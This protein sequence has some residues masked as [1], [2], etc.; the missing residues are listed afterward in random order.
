MQQ[1]LQLQQQQLQQQV[2][3]SQANVMM[4]PPPPPL[5][6]NAPQMPRSP[7]Q[8]PMNIN[9]LSKQAVQLQQKIA[10]L[11]Q[12]L[13][14]MGFDQGGN[15]VQG[16]PM[17]GEEEQPGPEGVGG[18]NQGRMPPQTPPDAGLASQQMM[19]MQ[20]TP[21]PQHTPKLQTEKEVPLS[22]PPQ[23]P[24]NFTFEV[25]LQRLEGMRLGLSVL[26]VTMHDVAALWVN[27]VSEGGAVDAWNKSVC[28]A[29]QVRSGDAITRVFDAAG[30][31]AKMMEELQSH[32][33][34]RLAVLRQS[35]SGVQENQS[36]PAQPAA[37]AVPAPAVP[38]PAPA[39]AKAPAQFTPPPK[40]MPAQRQDDMSQAASR[41]LGMSGLAPGLPEGDQDALD[42]QLKAAG[43][44]GLPMPLNAHSEV[45]TDDAGEL[46][47][48][49][50]IEE[51]GANGPLRFTVVL[52]RK[53]PGR[54]GIDVVLKREANFCGLLVYTVS[55]GGR[56][57]AWNRQSQMPY[58]V[59]PGDHILEVND[60]SISGDSNAQ[61]DKFAVRMIQELSK[62]QKNVHFTVERAQN[63]LGEELA[64][65]QD[66][67]SLVLPGD[68][69][70]RVEEQTI[71]RQVG[72]QKPD[73]QD[74]GGGKSAQMK[75]AKASVA[76]PKASVAAP[77]WQPKGS[78]L[79]PGH[80]EGGD[81]GE[82]GEDDAK[83]DEEDDEEDEQTP[84]V[85]E[86]TKESKES[87]EE[88]EKDK[89]TE[90]APEATP[91]LVPKEAPPKAEP[92]P[93]PAPPQ[94]ALTP[95]ATAPAPAT[96][97]E[98]VPAVPAA[99]EP[100]VP[101]VKAKPVGAG[102]MSPPPKGGSRP[103]PPPPKTVAPVKPG[104]VS[105]AKA[106]A[107]PK[108]AEAKISVPAPPSGPAPPPPEL[109]K[110]PSQG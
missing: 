20:P 39:P 58:R 44:P 37:A 1:Q 73:A 41:P 56:V 14:L 89:A 85:S 45:P 94:P 47:G 99:K 34:I 71:P 103:L 6:P 65:P 102:E 72:A 15:Q 104:D 9:A 7:A 79:P 43:P 51:S 88:T 68:L 110:A 40:A 80:S 38:A 29:F 12:Q 53:G 69:R 106:K 62:D 81:E 26:P 108:E 35:G 19:R 42:A 2:I 55:E 31:H 54:L 67:E 86:D 48:S 32:R 25:Y 109:A 11:Q 84:S 98:P 33:N 100:K 27:D 70:R 105:K 107:E 93:E 78:P 82:D 57:D 59:L 30:D 77:R 50:D 76:L 22:T 64:L 23:D 95:P 96:P 87:K 61:N 83:E 46:F 4:P 66:D 36:T 49:I 92:P 18:F 3:Q 75:A 90:A 17:M 28:P 101:P 63:S 97:A 60:I 21:P 16:G 91:T 24:N 13:G 74:A 52:A 5:P 8:L 10:Q